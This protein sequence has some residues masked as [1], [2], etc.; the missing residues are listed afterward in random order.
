M[1]KKQVTLHHNEKVELAEDFPEIGDSLPNNSLISPDLKES[2]LGDIQGKKMIL[3][4]PSVDTDVCANEVKKFNEQI[5]K[6]RE[7]DSANDFT[8]VMIS[9]DLPFAQKRFFDQHQIDQIQAYSHY[10]NSGVAEGL[11]VAMTNGPLNGLS[12]RAVFISE[13][14]NNRDE[15]SYAQLVPEIT[16]EPDYQDALKHLSQ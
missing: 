11:G 16:D 4:L 1:S 9:A 12:A 7:A 14:K 5:K 3:T 8:V 13:N 6:I 15:I 2:S 10:R